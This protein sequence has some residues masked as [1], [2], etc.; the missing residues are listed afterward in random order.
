[1]RNNYIIGWDLQTFCIDTRRKNC[2]IMLYSSTLRHFLR[3]E[4]RFN[5]HSGL[6]PAAW[7][8]TRLRLL[9]IVDCESLRHTCF[10]NVNVTIIPSRQITRRW[11]VSLNWAK[12]RNAYI[13]DWIMMLLLLRNATLQLHW[14]F[15]VYNVYNVL[16]L[17][18]FICRLNISLRHQIHEIQATRFISLASHR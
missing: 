7:I 3:L 17:S 16:F 8:N 13:F 6:L 1:M 2:R 10:M 5:G 15:I 12:I 11:F 18:P 9:F 14:D 4:K